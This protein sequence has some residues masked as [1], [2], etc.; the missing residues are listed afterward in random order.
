MADP[1]S[2]ET[3][4]I[5]V[6][7]QTPVASPQEV[8]PAFDD[9]AEM[10]KNIVST[11]TGEG[12]QKNYVP[13][14]DKSVLEEMQPPKSIA[15][16]I[17]RALFILIFLAGL[18]SLAFF[19]SQFT[20]KLDFFNEKFG[21]S[22]VSK[23]IAASNAEIIT[24]QTNLNLSKY[25]QAKA[26]LDKFSFD[27]DFY[28]QN[29]DIANSQ[30]SSNTEK[31][32][33]VSN[34]AILKPGLKES[35]IAAR[36]KLTESFTA[37]LV[38]TGKSKSLKSFFF[39][40]DADQ[41]DDSASSYELI[42]LYQTELQTGLNEKTAALAN[43][44]D[45]AAKREFKN[46]SQISRLIGNS[47]LNGVLV[48]T[49]FDALTD[50]EIYNLIKKVNSLIVNDL[51][52]IQTI[53]NARIKWS[54]IINEIDLRTTTVDRHYTENYYEDLG[55]VRYTSYD[56]DSEAR[57]ISIMGETKTIDTQNF[58]MIADLID[59]LN[60]SELFSNGEMH[61]FSK[62][63]SLESGYTASIR[64]SLDLEEEGDP[65]QSQEVVQDAEI[66]EFLLN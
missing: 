51:S 3:P 5:T 29:Y 36:G 32:Q 48:Q 41:I 54:D 56:F 7:S 59:E 57:N 39:G 55:G 12:A 2:A 38:D 10:I 18:A 22:N 47:G 58:T 17:F 15:L 62:S 21:F 27:G 63:G 61:A 60:R 33:A 65:L 25:L 53:K 23:E 64:L 50:E 34:M 4:A 13:D 19:G 40:G 66:P 52:I 46:Y 43:S 11:E 8:V 31:S 20:D 37:P 16:A 44:A 26:Y 6:T 49:D 28:I 9:N 42:G 14:I 45:S 24:L 35:F 30:T 1:N